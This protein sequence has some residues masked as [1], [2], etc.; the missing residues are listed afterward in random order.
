M[1]HR[2]VM[3]HRL[4]L[5]IS[6]VEHTASSRQFAD[7]SAG[8]VHPTHQ[9]CCNAT[10]GLCGGHSCSSRPGGPRQCCI[11]SILRSGRVC[12]SR[13]DVACILLES[14]RAVKAVPPP[15]QPSRS[16]AA[17]PNKA[18][19]RGDAW[20]SSNY[21]VPVT[22]AA[23]YNPRVAPKG[24]PH[25]T[26]P[27]PPLCLE[28]SRFENMAARNAHARQ[29][30]VAEASGAAVWF[31]HVRKAGG[32]TL[33]R[34]FGQ[35]GNA[36]ARVRDNCWGL[37][38]Q[39]T[40]RAQQFPRVLKHMAERGLDLVS[41]EG[42]DFPPFA[43]RGMLDDTL[44]NFT[45]L[46]VVRH[47]IDLLISHTVYDLD[48]KLRCN[49]RTRCPDSAPMDLAK[50]SDALLAIANGTGVTNTGSRKKG[51][52]LLSKGC[53]FDNY[54]T[55]VFSSSCAR[56]HAEV[57][58]RELRLALATLASFQLIFV[59]EWL[60]EMLPLARYQLGYSS[61]HFDVSNRNTH[62][63]PYEF[64]LEKWQPARREATLGSLSSATAL[65]RAL[66]AATTAQLEQHLAYDFL[67]YEQARVLARAHESHWLYQHE[68]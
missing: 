53:R 7:C 49:D 62:L 41:S 61:A 22:H 55:R 15:P 18:G 68:A 30:Y 11:P 67:L 35:P 58:V 25:E 3:H 9:V 66:P 10:C 44:S 26:L 64:S 27:F 17:A 36:R 57:G 56:P 40:M 23:C 4:N 47:P 19:L 60:P 34:F 48:L 46:S 2:L 50:L 12:E 24:A 8:V 51:P 31:Q 63:R 5:S 37:P 16:A 59:L 32:T 38:G 65:R 14:Q 29:L 33:C 28:A 52:T 6:P 39:D 20:G 21:N 45:F 54:L 43:R 13:A 1:A 42:G